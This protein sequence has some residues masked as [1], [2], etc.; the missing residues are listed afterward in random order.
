M[1]PET[2][3][4]LGKMLK[5]IKFC[6]VASPDVIPRGMKQKKLKNVK[7]EDDF[8]GAVTFE[9]AELQFVT[10]GSYPLIFQAG[11]GGSCPQGSHSVTN[12]HGTKFCRK[13]RGKASE[14]KGVLGQ[15]R[16]AENKQRLEARKAKPAK[17]K[18]KQVGSKPISEA[19]KPTKKAVKGKTD[20][21][22]KVKKFTDKDGSEGYQL[23]VYGK[24]KGTFPNKEDANVKGEDIK[25]GM[26]WSDNGKAEIKKWKAKTAKPKAAKKHVKMS[27][28][29]NAVFKMQESILIR[30]KELKLSE[31]Q[32]KALTDDMKQDKSGV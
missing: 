28:S 12:K 15:A 6:D 21:A 29:D 30:N 22:I 20:D 14:A 2:A 32:I 26:E 31:N 19:A 11:E 25:A 24:P 18:A 1:K 10:T 23:T 7:F 27:E 3:K 9:E 13:S 4:K 5:S 17:P 8:A 16:R